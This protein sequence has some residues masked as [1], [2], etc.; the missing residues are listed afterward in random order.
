MYFAMVDCPSNGRAHAR[1]HA[2]APRGPKF[3][4]APGGV[5][6]DNVRSHA[7]TSPA[8]THL[9]WWREYRAGRTS[10]DANDPYRYTVEYKGADVGA[11]EPDVL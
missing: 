4:G 6:N 9:Y 2:S 8:S 5:L 1:H 10:T 7:N 3:G 11:Q